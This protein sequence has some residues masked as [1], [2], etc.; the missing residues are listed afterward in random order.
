VN[1]YERCVYLVSRALSRLLKLR[2]KAKEQ[3]ADA[4]KLLA[5]VEATA[6]SC[7]MSA[8]CK[9][10]FD[11][12]IRSLYDAIS[13]LGDLLANIDGAL[14]DVNAYDCSKEATS[15]IS[16]PEAK[17]AQWQQTVNLGAYYTGKWDGVSNG[18]ADRYFAELARDCDCKLQAPKP[19]LPPAPFP[20]GPL[21]PPRPGDVAGPIANFAEAM[22]ITDVQINLPPDV[23]PQ[24]CT[25][26]GQR[27][28]TGYTSSG[29]PIYKECVTAR[30]APP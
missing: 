25:Y 30:A 14:S 26:A 13:E 8:E 17:A 19:K 28:L 1:A 27:V 4:K 24:K 16:P 15:A 9:K 22:P 3:L 11:D 5:I 29:R 18:A 20:W 10:A 23:I 21:P 6:A 7:A 2:E 12:L